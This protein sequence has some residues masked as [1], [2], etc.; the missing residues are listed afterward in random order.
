MAIRSALPIIK[1][2]LNLFYSEI[3]QKPSN[4]KIG[5]LYYYKA[6]SHSVVIYF[7]NS[8]NYFFFY[9]DFFSISDSIQGKIPIIILL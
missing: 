6:Y 2:R 5:Y 4:K 9:S 1:T 8:N 3:S 7:R